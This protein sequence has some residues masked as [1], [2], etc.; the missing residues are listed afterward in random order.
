MTRYGSYVGM[1]PD[2]AKEHDPERGKILE[3]VEQLRHLEFCRPGPGH[4]E[5]PRRETKGGR[6]TPGQTAFLRLTRVS[7]SGGAT[8]SISAGENGYSTTML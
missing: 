7:S 8:F 3:P 4:Q 6:Q 5:R 2:T 1:T